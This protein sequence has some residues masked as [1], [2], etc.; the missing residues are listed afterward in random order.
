MLQDYAAVTECYLQN[1]ANPVMVEYSKQ[2]DIIIDY[3]KTVLPKFKKQENI[4]LLESMIDKINTAKEKKDM[5]YKNL[6]KIFLVKG[7]KLTKACKQIKT[8]EQIELA[9]KLASSLLKC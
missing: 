2:Y 3:I 9:L 4:Q 5:V 6:V 7:T 8:K 1:G